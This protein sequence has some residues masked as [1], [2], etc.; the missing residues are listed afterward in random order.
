M[1][2]ESSFVVFLYILFLYLIKEI[3]IKFFAK[4]D[5]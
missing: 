3:L 4:S 1:E 2:L 5:L